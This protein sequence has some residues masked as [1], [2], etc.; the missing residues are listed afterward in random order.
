MTKWLQIILNKYLE[1]LSKFLF[2]FV[3]NK[4]KPHNPIPADRKKQKRL[5]FALC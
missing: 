4:I 2:H 1:R 5:R 3:I